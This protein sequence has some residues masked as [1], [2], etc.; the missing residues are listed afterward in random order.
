MSEI[1][2]EQIFSA[3]SQIIDP[4]TGAAAID[5]AML[6]GITIQ[7]RKIGFIL[8]LK[9]DDVKR[10][11]WFEDSCKQAIHRF[12][13][14]TESITV[15]LTADKFSSAPDSP[16]APAQK[17]VWNHHPIVGVKRVIAVASGKGGVGKSTTSV[18]L[19]RA[20]ARAGKQVGLL[21]AD[22]YGPSI[23]RMMGVSGQPDTEDGLMLPPVK[24]GI[25]CMSMGLIAGE[26]AAIVWRGPKLSKAIA[27]LARGTNWTHHLPKGAMLDVLIV[28]M[29]PGTGDI[30][31]SMVQQVPLSGTVIVTTPQE[32]ALLDAR[33]C[34]D[35]F[36]K[37]NVPL[38][39]VIE[40]MSY[41]EDPTGARHTLFGTG[42]GEKL[43]AE[44][45]TTLLGSIPLD[46][47]LGS[48]LDTGSPTISSATQAPYDR[49]AERL[50]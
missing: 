48:A 33:K 35:M 41:F 39:G 14:D 34:A 8:S 2:K 47:S 18:Q 15:I 38:L 20:F 13:P 3:L 30:H 10:Q 27:T 17:A 50:S 45:N 37:V 42:G 5:P 44:K 36:M 9:P 23:P 26:D 4:E 24:D 46:P 16:Q 21:D 7:G 28:D 40:N 43:A 22:I 11:A 19:A 25:A 12:I 49:I 31:I 1:S 29:P 32:I 6:S